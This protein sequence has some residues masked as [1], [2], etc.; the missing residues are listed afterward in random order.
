[1]TQTHPDKTDQR[2]VKT[3]TKAHHFHHLSALVVRPC[4]KRPVE[5]RFRLR[6]LAIDV[7]G[8]LQS[9][10]ICQHSAH[11]PQARGEVGACTLTNVRAILACKG[12]CWSALSGE[13]LCC[14]H[15]QAVCQ[16]RAHNSQATADCPQKHVP[17]TQ[18]QRQSA[19]ARRETLF[20]FCVT[21]R[22]IV[23]N[24]INCWCTY[25]VWGR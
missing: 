16:K 3:W 5:L 13:P 6:I 25:T 12:F 19:G 9:Q 22:V 4:N 1:M 2:S 10:G 14:K 24:Q 18:K 8:Q 15:K 11:K 7:G 21:V 20:R 17:R 23:T